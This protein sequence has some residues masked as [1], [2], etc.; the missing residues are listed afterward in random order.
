MSDSEDKFKNS[1][2]R[3][4]DESAIK[5]QVKIAKEY[6]FPIK[7]NGRYAKMHATNCGDPKCVMCGN[8]RKFFNELTVQEQ[9]FNQSVNPARNKRSNGN[10]DN[11]ENIL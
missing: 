1:K 11:E 10:T 5:R 8:P 4:Q 6:D 3:H 7:D 9:R 2:R